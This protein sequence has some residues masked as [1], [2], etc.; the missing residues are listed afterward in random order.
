MFWREASSH[1]N[2]K[3][4]GKGLSIWLPSQVPFLVMSD[5][6]ALRCQQIASEA[7][8]CGFVLESRMR[9]AALI[10]ARSKVIRQSSVD[11]FQKGLSDRQSRIAFDE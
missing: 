6:F 4:V 3:A 10:A 1:G 5:A 8:R 2:H 7:Q 9:K 11:D